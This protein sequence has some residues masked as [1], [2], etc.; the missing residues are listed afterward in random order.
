M[1]AEADPA[2]ILFLFADG[3]GLGSDD[4]DVNP[5]AA[6]AMPRL[7]DLVGGPLTASVAERVDDHLVLRALDARLGH[8][9]LPQSATGQTALLTGRNAADVMSGH[10]G[11]WPGP[12][13]QRELEE[14]TLVH[15][16][17]GSAELSNAYP[18][19]YFAALD[20]GRA[21]VNVP[22]Y[23]A[24]QAGVS[25]F[26]LDDYRAGRGLAADLT[27]EHFAHLDASIE[28]LS[29]RGAGRRLAAQAGRAS[30]T[31]FDLWWTDRIGH[32]GT[33]AEAVAFA[34]RFDAFLAGVLDG[35]DGTTLLL[36]SDHG[37]FEDKS[38]RSHTARPVPLLAVGPKADAFSTCTSLLDVY[39][40]VLRVWSA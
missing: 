15:A 28:P 39:P 10:Y 8:E 21:R 2:R 32:R 9:G 1:S 13:L 34:E 20:A 33:F 29:A 6:A 17:P 12:T 3:V 25:L 19:G 38:T 5:L 14:N 27:G 18:P 26:D 37:N 35:L 11:P 4:A 16:A 31:F 22:V 40:A 24:R 30:F 23:A 7:N 36:T